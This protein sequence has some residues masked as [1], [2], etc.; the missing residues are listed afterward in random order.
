MQGQATEKEQGV[1]SPGSR[2]EGL[3]PWRVSG[4]GCGGEAVTR[5][6]AGGPHDETG[7]HVRTD[8]GARCPPPTW[9]TQRE[10]ALCKLGRDLTLAS[11]GS[12][13]PRSG[14]SASRTMGD[15][16]TAVGREP[17]A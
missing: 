9:R 16:P 11:R 5:G 10:G 8:A 14:T 15:E 6:P 2:A 12:Q 1:V 13:V 7:T 3:S 4:G 17:A